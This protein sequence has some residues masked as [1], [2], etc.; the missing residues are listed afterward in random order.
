MKRFFIITLVFCIISIPFLAGCTATCDGGTCRGLGYEIGVCYAEACS[1]ISVDSDW[2]SMLNIYDSAVEGKDYSKPRL[3]WIEYDQGTSGNLTVSM[4]IYNEFW[5]YRF[6]ILF[7]QDG[8]ILDKVNVAGAADLATIHMVKGT[9]SKSFN[10][11]LTNK[12][13]TGGEVYYIINTF[14]SNKRR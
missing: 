8:I 7:V 2:S 13:E 10:V 6:E 12:K 9:F 3:E 14:V 5:L 11:D 1:C 4:E